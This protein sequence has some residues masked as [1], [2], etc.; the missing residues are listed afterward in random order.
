M[1]GE[2]PDVTIVIPYFMMGI[3][4]FVIIGIYLIGESKAKWLQWYK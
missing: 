2:W 4:I 1:I 3:W